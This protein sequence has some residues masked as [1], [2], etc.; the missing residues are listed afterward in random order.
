MRVFLI[1]AFTPIAIAVLACG[2][3]QA[4]SA[5]QTSIDAFIAEPMPPSVRV[6][7]TELDGPLFADA[8]GKV[9]YIWPAKG[10]RVGRTGDELG[11]SPNCEDKRITVSAGTMPPYPAGLELPDASTRPTCAQVWPPVLAA[12]DAKP[13]GKW[14]TISRANGSKQWTYE[15]YPVYTSA[16]DREA[17]APVG[18]AVIRAKGDSGNLREP[19]GPLADVPAQFVVVS[20]Q[21]GRFL[22]RV[23][24]PVVYTSDKDAPNKSNCDKTCQSEWQPVLAAMAAP[25][26]RGE[27]GVIERSPG[28]RQWTFRKMPVYTR[29]ADAVADKYRPHGFD[30]SDVPG[31]HIAYVRLGPNIPKGFSIQDTTRGQ[32]VADPQG[33]TVYAYSCIDDAADMQP[34][35]HPNQTQAYRYAV[36]GHSDPV[37]CVK[38]FPYVIAEKGAKSDSKTW[39][40]VSIDPA[41]GKYATPGQAGALNVWAYR[42]RPI[43]TFIRDH[44]PGDLEGDAWGEMNGFRNGF[45]AIWMRDQFG[46]FNEETRTRE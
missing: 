38:T 44:A 33:R 28:V 15:G 18:S 24:G 4:Q 30:G 16:L 13:V 46:L 26:S 29:V 22:A 17:A 19:I 7:Q 35:D 3:A 8:A 34:C 9:F 43:Y 32:V 23:D 37:R 31:W 40:V 39:S 14:N 42:D 11:K 1:A 36:C 10:Q 21:T 5:K 12:N 27:W 6:V 20:A 25:Q 2:G 41:S 45:H